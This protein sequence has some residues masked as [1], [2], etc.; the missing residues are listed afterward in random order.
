MGSVPGLETVDARR[1]DPFLNRTDSQIEFALAG[2]SW[3]NGA[4]I[5]GEQNEFIGAEA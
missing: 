1:R 4:Q 5:T 2:M 3:M